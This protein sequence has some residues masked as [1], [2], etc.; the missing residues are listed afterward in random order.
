MKRGKI[1][2]FNA[3][4]GFGFLVELETNLEYYFKEKNLQSQVQD[5]DIVEFELISA[6]RGLEA[7]NVKK[8][9]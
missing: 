7:I 3:K 5:N 9:E 1:K 2:F 6:K 4:S 8:L